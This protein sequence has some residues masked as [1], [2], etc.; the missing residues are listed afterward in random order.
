MNLTIL[1]VWGAYPE[2]DSS[3]SSLLL[4][5]DNFN[6]LIDCGSGVISQLQKYIP[7]SNL[8]ALVVSHYHND[9]IADIGCLQYGLMIQKH[10]GNYKKLL[11]IYA[12]KQDERFNTFNYEG[13]AEAIEIIE[14]QIVTI[15]PF[16][17]SFCETVHPVYTLGM[18]FEVGG[19]QLVYTSDTEWSEKLIDFSMGADLIVCEANLFEAQLGKV[20]GHL[21][22]GQAGELAKQANAQKLVLTHL[23]HY[24]DHNDILKNARDSFTGDVILAEQGL[25]I[26]L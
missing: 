8:D 19:K 12:H 15:G 6:L 4:T 18:K 3:T 10:L 1:G 21:T 26:E 16:T 9:H 14:N 2:A 7:I 5:H 25:K 13:V 20:N 24:G 17:V 23:P 22:G 11:P